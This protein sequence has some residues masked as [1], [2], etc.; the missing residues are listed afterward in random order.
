MAQLQFERN[1]KKRNTEKLMKSMENGNKS[2]VGYLFDGEK[3]SVEVFDATTL[4][5]LY[6][7]NNMFMFLY[8]KNIYYLAFQVKLMGFGN[9]LLRIHVPNEGDY[10][11]CAFYISDYYDDVV[12]LLK[13]KT[14]V[15]KA[16]ADCI[17]DRYGSTDNIYTQSIDNIKTI[18]AIYD[19]RGDMVSFMKSIRDSHDLL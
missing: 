16:I 17:I 6:L 3:T 10:P 4:E 1:S 8:D 7:T 14:N 12:D 18:D 11:A 5:K 2:L 19:N 15:L 13:G 9:F